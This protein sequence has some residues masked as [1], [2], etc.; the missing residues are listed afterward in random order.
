MSSLRPRLEAL[1]N[2]MCSERFPT[3]SRKATDS[4]VSR[5]PLV[6]ISTGV[7]GKA[8]LSSARIS[9]KAGCNRGSPS[10]MGVADSPMVIGLAGSRNAIVRAIS[11]SDLTPAGMTRTPGGLFL[12]LQKTQCESQ[13]EVTG[14][15]FASFADARMRRSRSAEVVVF[16]AL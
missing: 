11:T 12:W 6:V 10:M 4:A 8:R 7:S 5:L 13:R 3:L 9:L 1:F 14:S 16:I 2:E 15:T